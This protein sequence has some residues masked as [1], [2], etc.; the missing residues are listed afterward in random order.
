MENE[1][2]LQTLAADAARLRD[3]AAR[4]LAARV[5]SCPGWTVTDLVR[6]V[7]TVYQHK[8]ET[9]R[10][11]EFPTSWPPDTPDQEPV[12]ALDAAFADLITEFAT[13]KPDES[14]VTWFTPDQTVGFWVRRMAQESVIHRVDAELALAEPIAPIP[15]DL[16]VDGIDEVLVRFLSY[17]SREW[18]EEFIEGL[19]G[20]DNEAVLVSAGG[21]GWL[22]RLG[23]DGIDVERVR[24]G[25]DG[26]DVERGDGTPAAALATLSG[27]PGAVLLWLWRRADD[28]D[29][30]F[31]GD[32][33]LIV[34]LRELLGT[35]TQ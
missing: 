21:Q 18:S 35:A 25:R 33:A 14:A 34:K 5:P 22:V 26:V 6:H 11:G 30:T 17:G 2:Y 4:D 28:A 16:A 24:L 23:R 12:G 32:P 27:D 20:C 7:A 1:R 8:T 10:R 9:M 29:V 3:I 31:D 13:R 19:A 15:V